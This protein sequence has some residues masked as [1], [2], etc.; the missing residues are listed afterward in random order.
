MIIWVCKACGFIGEGDNPPEKCPIC[1]A[2]ASEFEMRLNEYPED[3]KSDTWRC[4]I[5]GFIFEGDTPPERCPVCGAAPNDFFP[6]LSEDEILEISK[7]QKED[8][9]NQDDQKGKSWRCTVCGYI[10]EGETPPDDCP[11]CHADSSKFVQI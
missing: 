4:E 5:C 2:G 8:N 6:L 9:K 11:V 1:G 7:K 3:V 10:Y